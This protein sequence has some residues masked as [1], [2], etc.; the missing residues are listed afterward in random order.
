M[1]PLTLEQQAQRIKEFTAVKIL[2]IKLFLILDILKK[3][4][5]MNEN[6]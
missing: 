5:I 1:C 2:G 3:Y 6:L 4:K